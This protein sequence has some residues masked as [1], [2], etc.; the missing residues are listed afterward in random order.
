MAHHTLLVLDQIL[1][2]TLG[3]IMYLATL[4]AITPRKF[5]ARTDHLVT[6]QPQSL[7]GSIP[8]RTVRQKQLLSGVRSQDILLHR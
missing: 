1:P 7:V 5:Q 3:L 6:A 4:K 8:S 2:H